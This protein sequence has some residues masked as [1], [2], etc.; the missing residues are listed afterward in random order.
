M[1]CT[2]DYRICQT[3]FSNFHRKDVFKI[4]N[5]I[6]VRFKKWRTTSKLTSTQ[7]S[8]DTGIRPSTISDIENDRVI[9][10]GKT[11]IPLYR[12]YNMPITYILTGE[13]NLTSNEKELLKTYKQLDDTNKDIA[14]MKV[15]HIL[16][17]QDVKKLHEH[18]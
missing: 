6:G 14:M 17:E 11:I 10:S 7:I 8:A 1:H 3:L 18:Q 5:S 16:E 9:P 12:N 2:T 15:R 4:D 13:E